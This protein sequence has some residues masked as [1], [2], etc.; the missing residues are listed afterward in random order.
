[1]SNSLSFIGRLAKDAETRQTPSGKSVTG[2][3]VA[4]DVGFGDHKRTNWFS[5]SIWGA[6]GEKLAQYLVKG[7]RVFVTGEFSSR[8]YQTNGENRTALEVAVREID[9]VSKPEHQ[10]K[11][12][13]QQTAP[14]GGEFDDDIPF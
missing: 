10:Q 6:R 11:H 8:E 4:N 7:S 12:E 1:M 14:Q 13:R 5:C 9:F 2:F 3:R